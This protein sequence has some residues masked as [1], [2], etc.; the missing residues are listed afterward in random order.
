MNF[1]DCPDPPSESEFDAL[2]KE[3]HVPSQSPDFQPVRTL[4]KCI[5]EP[6]TGN[7]TKEIENNKSLTQR[8]FTEEQQAVIN[9]VKRGESVF[10]TGCA[11]TGKSY[12]L[13]AIIEILPPSKLAITAPTGI[14]AVNIGGTTLHSWSGIGQ[15]NETKEKLSH[16]VRAKQSAL[17][18]WRSCQTLII[19]E[20]SM[21]DCE[22]FEKL[23]FIARSIRSNQQPFGGIQIVLCGDF[24][25][26][27]PVNKDQAAK[28]V[29]E[30]P[31][32]ESMVSLRISLSQVFRQSDDSFV[33]ML[34]ELRVG[35]VS[36][37]SKMSLSSCVNKKIDIANGIIP[38]KLCSIKN[39]VET[40]N[41]SRLNALPG[42]E[43][44]YVAIDS[45]DKF[46]LE[47]FKK[48]CTA[49]DILV[50]KLNAQVILLRN[51]ST[52]DGLVNGS[53]GFVVGFDFPS[54]KY[55]TS[56]DLK[57]AQ[58]GA[59]PLESKNDSKTR[60]PIV[61]FT[62]GRQIMIKEESFSVISQ[63]KVLV[64]RIQIPLLLAWAIT[65]HKCQGMT[66]DSAV[67]Q[68]DKI[69]ES[70]QGYVA[71]SRVKSLDGVFIISKREINWSKVFQAN[72]RAIQFYSNIDPTL[73]DF[74]DKNTPSIA[75]MLSYREKKTPSLDDSRGFEKASAILY[76]EK[77]LKV[78]YN[79]VLPPNAF[80]T[81]SVKSSAL[82][83]A[84]S[85]YNRKP[86]ESSLLGKRNGFAPAS[87][88]VAGVKK[89]N[90]KILPDEP[91]DLTQE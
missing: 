90:A 71:L 86:S 45:G 51:L 38:T 50:L 52:S 76:P 16:I 12:V 28:F 73:R 85:V 34:G 20:I 10:F 63:G 62:N 44:S 89:S 42:Q 66:M 88:Y 49:P 79:E 21:L 58:N 72:D 78:D 91:I 2:F 81:N 61:K 13:K 55:T 64:Q 87:E 27:P 23:E 11:G 70:G 74:I 5:T 26:L 36:N 3:C 22:L 17:S 6:V 35:V 47:S 46:A 43:V 83:F 57:G 60:Y 59:T 25:Q 32:F 14:A 41:L 82:I 29:F 77:P 68:F 18:N 84:T 54:K 15:G 67:L 33:K 53:R 1:D 80:S 65:I 7:K 48:N 19:D 39:E 30:S 75:R 69:F 40:E 4:P 56:S 37:L 31:L 8:K 9:A 24:L